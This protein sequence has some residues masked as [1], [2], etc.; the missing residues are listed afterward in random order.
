M[1]IKIKILMAVVGIILI[2][3]G[4]ITGYFFGQRN[5]LTQQKEK[6]MEYNKS[7]EAIK[8]VANKILIARK[9]NDASG[10]YDLACDDPNKRPKD[11][12]IKSYEKEASGYIGTTQV[13]D[14]NIVGESAKVYVTYGVKNLLNE[15]FTDKTWIF[16]LKNGKWCIDIYMKIN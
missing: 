13:S 14:I 12:Y 10:L 8:A 16:N 6:E 2:A 9:F 1:T 4:L 11:E 5:L 7:A 3:V 15:S